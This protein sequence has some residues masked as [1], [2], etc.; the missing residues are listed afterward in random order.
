VPWPPNV[1]AT[2]P[3]FVMGTLAVACDTSAHVKANK[4]EMAYG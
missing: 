2:Y 3:V 4:A 1:T